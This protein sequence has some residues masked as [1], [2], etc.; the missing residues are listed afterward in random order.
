MTSLGPIPLPLVL[1]VAG[2]AVAALV[3]RLLAGALP[4]PRWATAGTFIDMLLVGLIAGRLAFVLQWWPQYAADP[5][6]IVRPGDGGYALWVAIPAGL[7]FGAWRVRKR[8]ELRRSVAWGSAAGLVAWAILAA[9]I[10][11][12]QR[13]VVHLP[14]VELTRLEGETVRLTELGQRPMVVNL[15]ATWC[16]PCRR[17]MP[18]LAEAQ[19]R[20]L[21]LIFVF[22]NQG[23]GA[24]HVDRFL[25]GGALALRNVVLDPASSV[26]RATGARGLPTT[27]FFD[28]QGRLADVHMGELTR[29]SL[30]QKLRRLQPVHP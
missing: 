3:A 23:E 24:P 4:G 28:A 22:V 14:D 5:W 7:A 6:A 26:A 11:L 20:H 16:P 25:R 10:A 2:L 9:A 18:V 30:E 17:E 1:L 12:M 15:W 13:S 19:A 8:P 27:L 21:G 29:A